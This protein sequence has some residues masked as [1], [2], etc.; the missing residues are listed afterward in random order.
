FALAKA[1]EDLGRDEAAFAELLEAN[2]LRRSLIQYDEAAAQRRF[3]RLRAIFT[4]KLISGADGHGAGSELPIFV[5][6]FP[7]SGTSLIEQ[8]LASHPSVHGAGELGHLGRI[9]GGLRAQRVGFPECLPKLP[10]NAM[11]IL[12]EEYLKRIRPLAPAALRISDKLPANYM[13]L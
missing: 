10:P 2:R 11:A 6:G 4:A 12:G 13:F 8:I 9:A 5:V 1:H 7:R 3:E